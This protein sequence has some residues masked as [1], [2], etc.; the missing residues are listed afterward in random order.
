MAIYNSESN[1]ALSLEGVHLYHFPMSS[2]SQR[3][4]FG[5]AEKGVA[6]ESHILD[7]RA[8]EHLT[9]RYK[10]INPNAVVPTLVH[11]GQVILE[12]NDILFYLD[13][14]F[15]GPSLVSADV[16]DQDIAH[17]LIDLSS[18]NQIAL[19]T[20][21]HELLFRDS[22]VFTPEDL[23]AKAK[24]GAFDESLAF[25]KDFAENGEAWQA[26][27]TQASADMNAALAQ[28]EARL[29]DSV[30]LTGPEFGVVDISWSVNLF[31]LRLCKY[32]LEAYPRV[33]QW[34]DQVLERP[35]F[36]AAVSEYKP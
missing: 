27:V 13:E 5:L 14:I 36:K 31:R 6:W 1:E 30:W 17:A 26:R 2:C 29:T 24:A 25:M 32:D 35:A 9:P 15:E 22:L 20:L 34:A 7:M 8:D 21:T 16:K 28:L 18:D 33:N 4:R 12:S 19:K 3:V 10:A 11:D 23:D